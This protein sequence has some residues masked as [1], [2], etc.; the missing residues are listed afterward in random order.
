MHFCSVQVLA[1]VYTLKQLLVPPPRSPQVSQPGPPRT[2]SH[3]TPVPPAV[4]R[5]P[6][7]GGQEDVLP[8]PGTLSTGVPARP[9]AHKLPL[10]TSSSSSLAWTCA[11][12]PRRSPPHTRDHC[13]RHH[14]RRELKSTLKTWKADLVLHDGTDSQHGA[15]S[16]GGG[17]GSD[18]PTGGVCRGG[19]LTPLPQYLLGGGRGRRRRRPGKEGRNAP[20]KTQDSSPS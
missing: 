4:W 7:P 14:R 20:H 10:N 8:T 16:E 17:L 13:G 6:V 1:P 2:S 9:A 11:W 19:R 5:G 15:H 3:S 12:R 18:L